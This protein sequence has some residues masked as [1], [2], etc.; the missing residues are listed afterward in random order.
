MSICNPF[1]RAEHPFDR[2]FI[3]N[4]QQ[5]EEGQAEKQRQAPGKVSANVKRDCV[6]S[7]G[8][9]GKNN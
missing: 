2:Q 5:V 6:W 1:S 9:E 4:R 3:I 8:V 7:H